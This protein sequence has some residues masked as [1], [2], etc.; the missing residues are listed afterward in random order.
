MKIPKMAEINGDNLSR[1]TVHF[2]MSNIKSTEE[3]EICQCRIY[4]CSVFSL[5]LSSLIRQYSPSSA[6]FSVLSFEFDFKCCTLVCQFFFLL[7]VSLAA[8]KRW[9]FI[10]CCKLVCAQ[11]QLISFSLVVSL[12]AAAAQLYDAFILPFCRRQHTIECM[13]SLRSSLAWL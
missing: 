3:I 6:F 1:V 11:S 5:S 4:I 9:K 10:E 12:H 13:N 8:S 7:H 2:T